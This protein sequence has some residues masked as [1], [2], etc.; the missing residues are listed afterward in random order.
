MNLLVHVGAPP[1]VV[2]AGID[3]NS[4]VYDAVPDGICVCSRSESLVS[5]LLCVLRPKDCS[6]AVVSPFKEF[7]QHSAHSLIGLV[8][9]PFIDDEDGKSSVFF[10]NFTLPCGRSC[11]LVHASSKSGIRL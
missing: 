8:K 10:K 9:E 1:H 3:P 7:K 6:C 5:V 2:R 11:A 4:V